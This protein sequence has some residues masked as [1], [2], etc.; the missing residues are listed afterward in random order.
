MRG[1]C[2]CAQLGLDNARPRPR[3]FPTLIG[4]AVDFHA[5]RRALSL[6]GVAATLLMTKRWCSRTCPLALDLFFCLRSI[7]CVCVFVLTV[8]ADVRY[9][10][11]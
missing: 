9:A 6:T 4:A 11:R 5:E 2:V 10:R 1:V 3:S 8:L 7:E